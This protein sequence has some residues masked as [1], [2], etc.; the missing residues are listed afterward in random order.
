[1]TRTR[2]FRRCRLSVNSPSPMARVQVWHMICR[3]SLVAHFQ[4]V[5]KD[6][7]ASP[8]KSTWSW[9]Y[10]SWKMLQCNPK[11]S[12]KLCFSGHPKHPNSISLRPKR[13]PGQV[14]VMGG[15]CHGRPS[16]SVEAWQ[17]S[18]QRWATL[19]SMQMRRCLGCDGL[20]FTFF[21]CV[22]IM[23]YTISLLHPLA[24]FSKESELYKLSIL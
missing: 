11:K 16:A 1:M 3:Q 21:D 13:S 18:G 7:D 5:G 10:F 24:M 6:H 9:A 2:S 12:P 19:P 23:S 22:H 4:F 8:P 14:L 20:F 15:L 17:I